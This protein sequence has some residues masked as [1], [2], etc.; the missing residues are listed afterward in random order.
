MDTFKVVMMW[1]GM[2]V[3][4]VLVTWGI[5]KLLAKYGTQIVAGCKA[6]NSYISSS[7][8]KVV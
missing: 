5:I 3:S 1:L 4:A 6:A 8:K 7:I 2:L